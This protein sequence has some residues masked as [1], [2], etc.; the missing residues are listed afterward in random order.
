KGIATYP[1]FRLRD[2]GR[3]H[4]AAQPGGRHVVGLSPSPAAPARQLAGPVRA[5]GVPARQPA[6]PVRAAAAPARQP[7]GPVRAVA[8]P[9][10]RAAVPVVAAPVTRRT[11]G[12]AGYRADRSPVRR[13]TCQS[14]YPTAG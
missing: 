14:G 9:A 7:A 11:S 3:A 5:A 1:D 8:A 4:A 10:R 13:P 6:A 2:R 12:T